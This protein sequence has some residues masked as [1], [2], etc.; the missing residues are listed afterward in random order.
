MRSIFVCALFSAV[1]KTVSV[2]PPR[3]QYC[4][5]SIISGFFF[6]CSLIVPIPKHTLRNPHRHLA[7]SADSTKGPLITLIMDARNL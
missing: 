2:Y 7:Q 5:H 4:G 3:Q 6:P 1:V